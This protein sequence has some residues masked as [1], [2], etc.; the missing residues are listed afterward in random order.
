MELGNNFV[1][2]H[3][4]KFTGIPYSKP[5][6][7]CCA[8][9]SL[10]SLF[11][12]KKTIFTTNFSFAIYLYDSCVFFYLVETVFFRMAFFASFSL[13]IILAFCTTLYELSSEY[14]FLLSFENDKKEHISFQLF[15]FSFRHMRSLVIIGGG[16]VVVAAPNNFPIY[17]SALVMQ[18]GFRARCGKLFMRILYNNTFSLA[19]SECHLFY[20]ALFARTFSYTIPYDIFEFSFSVVV[21]SSIHSLFAFSTYFNGIFISQIFYVL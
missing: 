1:V 16:A 5:R 18:T 8:H 11:A 19:R 4:T 3:S 20:R 9:H 6:L 2:P 10:F 21:S 14:R 7:H 13:L 17:I 15:A 12:V